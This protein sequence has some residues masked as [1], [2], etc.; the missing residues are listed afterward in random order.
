MTADSI[1]VAVLKALEEIQTLSGREWVPLTDAS[2]PI[3]RLPGFESPNGVEFTC[4]IEEYLKCEVPLDENLCVE[5]LGG[6]HRRARSV[7][8]IIARLEELVTVNN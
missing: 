7:G 2:K 5:D 6:G 8:Q 1:R 3:S 4:L